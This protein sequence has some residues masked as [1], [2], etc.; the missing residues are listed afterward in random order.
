MNGVLGLNSVLLGTKLDAEQRDLAETMQRSGEALLVILNDI[1]DLARMDAG[2]MSLLSEP[3]D[4]QSAARDVVALFRGQAANKRLKLTLSC[5]EALPLA[6]GDRNRI[7]QVLL[8]LVSNAVKFTEHGSVAIRLARHDQQVVRIDVADTGI[9]IPAARLDRLFQ[10]FSQ[11]E[12]GLTRRFGGAGLGLIISLRLV[13]G[14]GGTLGVTTEEQIGS[15]FTI[16]LPIAPAGSIQQTSS[17]ITSDVQAP[18]LVA[19][20]DPVMRR[21]TSL[22][23]SQLGIESVQVEDGKTALETWRLGEF[24][25]LLIDHHLP[26]IDGEAVTQA[27]RAAEMAAHRARTPVIGLI[28]EDLP[29]DRQACLIADMDEVLTTPITAADIH[30]V[31]SLWMLVKD[32]LDAGR[33]CPETTAVTG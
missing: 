21:V 16:L 17:T 15:V 3:I 11:V 12:S 31:L 18:I 2:K 5:A 22:L 25:A 32:G 10:P 6:L 23:V 26:E 1:L 9:G 4:L 7:R 8:N 30:R 28:G 14:M 13:E 20:G 27:I 33:G 29:Q 19:I 24:A